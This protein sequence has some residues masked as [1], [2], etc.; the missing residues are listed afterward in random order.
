MTT[1]VRRA[2]ATGLFVAVCAAGCQSPPPRAAYSD[3]P[4]LVSRQPVMQAGG[5]QPTYKPPPGLASAIKPPPPPETPRVARTRLT[6]EIPPRPTGVASEGP[7]LPA[8]PP[9]PAVAPPAVMAPLR[10]QPLERTEPAPARPAMPQATVVEAPAPMPPPPAQTTG[11]APEAPKPATIAPVSGVTTFKEEGR[12]GH[13]ND[14]SRLR[15]ELDR[16]YRGHMD[17]R[18]K[19]VS[20]EDALGGKVRL[21]NHPQ[22]GEFRAGDVVE[23]YG[24]LVREPGGESWSQYPRYHVKEIKLIERR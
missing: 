4:L 14:Y 1:R 15:G 9:T 20:E 12:Y 3:N 5:S 2:G 18:F 22:L 8:P 17:L 24:E 23:V 11:P 7:A 16:H 13:A 21:E 6:G 19:P 10:S